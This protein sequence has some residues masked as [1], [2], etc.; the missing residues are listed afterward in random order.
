M[1]GLRRNLQRPDSNAQ[2]SRFQLL[3]PWPGDALQFTSAVERAARL[4]TAARRGISAAFGLKVSGWRVLRLVSRRGTDITIAEAARGLNLTRQSVHEVVRELRA[5]RLIHTE[6][7]S[8]NRRA[9]KLV[10][11]T[12]GVRRLEKMEATMKLVLLEMTNDISLESL[13]GT[14]HLLQRMTRAYAPARQSLRDTG[15]EM[16]RPGSTGRARRTAQP[17]RAQRTGSTGPCS[18]SRYAPASE[19][20]RPVA[21]ATI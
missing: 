20:C 9:L 21:S 10:L 19:S 17:G 8:V 2:G 18:R 16:L 5:A 12:E 13:M 7:S 4:I 6:R 11:T 15:V 1:Q 3:S 14:T